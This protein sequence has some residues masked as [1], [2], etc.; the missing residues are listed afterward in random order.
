MQMAHLMVMAAC[1]DLMFEPGFTFSA[2]FFWL[3]SRFCADLAPLKRPIRGG[4][5]DVL[6]RE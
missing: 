5:V 4:Q 6:A 3:R 1:V 2:S